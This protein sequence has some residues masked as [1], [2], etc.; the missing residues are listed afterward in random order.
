MI[1]TRAARAMNLESYGLA[2][3]CRANLVVLN[4]GD[5]TNALRFHESPRFV[6]SQGRVVDAL[7][8][9]ELAQAGVG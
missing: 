5:L 6:I 8:M 2:A 9:R 4:Q 7:R 1:T 3:G